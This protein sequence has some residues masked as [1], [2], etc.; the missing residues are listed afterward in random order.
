M[1]ALYSYQIARQCKVQNAFALPSLPTSH[2]LSLCLGCLKN[3]FMSGLISSWT[4]LVFVHYKGIMHLS[5]NTYWIYMAADGWYL[6][7]FQYGLT[8]LVGF[9]RMLDYNKILPDFDQSRTTPSP[10]AFHFIFMGST[11]FQH[12][13]KKWKILQKRGCNLACIELI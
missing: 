12:R 2:S 13:I 10:T 1:Q 6:W 9:Y 5:S 7:G 3:I 11:G 8:V 4:R